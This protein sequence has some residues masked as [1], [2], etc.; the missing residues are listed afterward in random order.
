MTGLPLISLVKED[1]PAHS[2]LPNRKAKL[3]LRLPPVILNTAL[4][5]FPQVV[6]AFDLMLA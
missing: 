2:A 4:L 6:L 1:G 5:F 3:T